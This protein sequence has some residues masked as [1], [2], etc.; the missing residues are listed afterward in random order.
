L[1]CGVEFV[2]WW[3]FEGGGTALKR[4]IGTT[5]SR[6]FTRMK[7]WVL[8]DE[9]EQR[10][11]GRGGIRKAGRQERRLGKENENYGF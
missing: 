9:V 1:W 5:D 2:W 6:E 8:G 7:T 10:R 11:E 3:G 4:K